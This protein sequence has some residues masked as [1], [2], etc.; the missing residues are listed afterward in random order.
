[1][2]SGAS[3][4]PPLLTSAPHAREF[5]VEERLRPAPAP[6]RFHLGIAD[7]QLLHAATASRGGKEHV[8]PLSPFLLSLRMRGF[9]TVVP[10]CRRA[11]AA[12]LI[13]VLQNQTNALV[14]LRVPCRC[15]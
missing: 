6:P 4:S 14:S 13:H 7:L 1:M 9:L 3:P 11:I 15:F 12:A 5:L 10:Q 2:G 8:V